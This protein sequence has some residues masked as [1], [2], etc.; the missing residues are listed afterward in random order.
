MY[1]YLEGILP[2]LELAIDYIIDMALDSLNS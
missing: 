1:E 2:F